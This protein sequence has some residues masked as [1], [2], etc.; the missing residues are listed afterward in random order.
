LIVSIAIPAYDRKVSV[1]TMASVLSEVPLATAAGIGLKFQFLPGSSNIA[2]AR[3]QIAQ[4]FLDSGADRLV[5]VDADVSWA[6]GALLRLAGHD[7][8]F[9]G[10]AYRYKSDEERYPVLWLD[11]RNLVSDHRGLLEVAGVPGGFL[12]LDRSVFLKL[13]EARPA[14]YRHF[15]RRLNAW[16]SAP[17]RDGDLLGE[18]NAFCADWRAIGGQVWLDPE[19]TLTH[20]DGAT[21]Y[22]G[23]IGRWLLNRNSPTG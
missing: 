13:R 6:A 12:A 1:E 21:A 3:N 15:E 11:Q 18:D 2:H 23:R 9:V 22:A 16:F 20:H 10:G 5:F 7:A 4:D 17:Y 19:L 8:P 14:P